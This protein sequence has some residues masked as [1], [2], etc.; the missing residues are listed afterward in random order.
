MATQALVLGAGASWHYGFPLA[1]EIAYKTSTKSWSVE[2]LKLCGIEQVA[3]E[4]FADSLRE[5]LSTSIDDFLSYETE[6]GV[7]A[8]GKAIL[9]YFIAEQEHIQNLSAKPNPH[10]YE[11]LASRLIVP[12]LSLFPARD[13]AIVTFNYDRSLDRSLLGSLVS[14]FRSKHSLPEIVA[15]FKRLPIVHIYGQLGYLPGLGA[16]PR[17]EREYGPISSKDG[18]DRA[19]AAMHLLPEVITLGRDGTNI[20]EA[21]ALIARATDVSFLGFAYSADNLS[22]LGLAP[23]ATAGKKFSGTKLGF[24]SDEQIL[25]LKVRLEKFGVRLNSAWSDEVASALTNYPTT[26]LGPAL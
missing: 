10:W 23:P 18:M 7:V 6:P 15:A 5:S 2:R 8:L 16:D 14:R 21:E 19:V 22:A 24:N 26:I 17:L 1:R 12:D 9:A 25:E 13:I 3:A 4:S 11:T 20:A